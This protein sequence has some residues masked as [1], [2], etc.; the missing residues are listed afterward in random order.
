MSAEPVEPIESRAEKS[1]SASRGKTAV[2]IFFVVLGLFKHFGRGL[3]NAEVEETAV[4]PRRY[5]TIPFREPGQ[6]QKKGN[7]DTQSDTRSAGIGSIS[8][9]IRETRESYR[10]ERDGS[11]YLSATHSIVE[12]KTTID[13]KELPGSQETDT[14]LPDRAN[15]EFTRCQLTLS[16]DRRTRMIYENRVSDD[17]GKLHEINVEAEIEF[18]KGDWKQFTDGD[19]VSVRYTESG[20]KDLTSSYEKLFTQIFTESLRGS[21]PEKLDAGESLNV[22][23]KI[24]SMPNSTIVQIKK[25]SIRLRMDPWTSKSPLDL[26]TNSVR[27]V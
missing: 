5:T 22:T 15:G 24:T 8:L 21:H 25:Q 4:N 3:R 2:L 19:E 17:E 26:P 16:E 7:A 23:L 6:A 11:Y 13:G 10:M 12:T 14:E 18:V 20:L 9:S 1:K 27:A